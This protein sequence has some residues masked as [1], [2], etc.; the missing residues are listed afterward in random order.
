[1]SEVTNESE[2]SLDIIGDI[3]YL[4]KAG[5][6]KTLFRE[7]DNA[8]TA[9]MDAKKEQKDIKFKESYIVKVDTSKAKWT[10]DPVDFLEKLFDAMEKENDNAETTD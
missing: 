1:M 8:I 10:V 2:E 3:F 4:L 6:G 9:L 7:E 5:N